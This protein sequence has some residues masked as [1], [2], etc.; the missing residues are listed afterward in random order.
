MIFVSYAWIDKEPDYE[1][2]QFINTLRKLGYDAQCDVIAKGNKTAVNF[3][4]LMAEKMYE[5]EKVIII[6]SQR[7]KKKADSFE[8]GVGIEYEY[9]LEDIKYND[10]KYIL[11]CFKD[12]DVKYV[13]EFLRGRE[14]LQIDE[15]PD[16][17]LLR[18]LNNVADYQFS[19]VNANKIESYSIDFTKK[20]QKK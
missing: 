14:I 15:M 11:V 19:D 20:K 2:L 4:R 16:E 6:L 12:Y 1:V 18:R 8:G 10:N 17:K 7:Y 9:I 5:A 3:N 13:P